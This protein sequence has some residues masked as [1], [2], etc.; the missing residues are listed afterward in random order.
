MVKIR[1][2][3]KGMDET[4][5]FWTHGNKPLRIEG[6]VEADLEY[7]L[8]MHEDEHPFKH[9]LERDLEKIRAGVSPLTGQPLRWGRKRRAQAIRGIRE[10]LAGLHTPTPEGMPGRK[11]L[12]RVAETHTKMYIDSAGAIL[13]H[14]VALM[15]RNEGVNLTDAVMLIA[16]AFLKKVVTHVAQRASD[17]APFWHGD[18]RRSIMGYVENTLVAIGPAQPNLA[19]W[20]QIMEK[21]PNS[22][23]M[24]K[25]G[26][27]LLA[28]LASA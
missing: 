2:N 15:V 5:K 10:N 27:A 12:T 9:M 14:A 28:S 8:K 24:M 6:R 21:A 7:A 25:E 20:K 13:P 4:L 23:K 1:I 19:H 22:R 18:L 17:N 16:D 26:V 3:V 11:F